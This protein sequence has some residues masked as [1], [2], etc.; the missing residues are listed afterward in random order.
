[1]LCPIK[2]ISKETCHDILE[3]LSKRKRVFPASRHRTSRRC[4]TPPQVCGVI[5]PS[6]KLKILLS[7]FSLIH[8]CA[9]ILFSLQRKWEREALFLARKPWP[10]E[11]ADAVYKAPL[12]GR[13]LP[14][15]CWLL[16]CVSSLYH[17]M[18]QLGAH[19]ENVSIEFQVLWAEGPRWASAIGLVSC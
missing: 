18:P 9:Q 2:I 16:V 8:T 12:V 17:K 3:T 6:A 1:M 19:K 13:A 10:T 5:H 7:S 14:L 11:Q 4:E 15:V